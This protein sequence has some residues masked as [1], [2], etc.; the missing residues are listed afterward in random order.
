MEA[1]S[2]VAR[3][4]SILRNLLNNY[5][6]FLEEDTI[7]HEINQYL[8]RLKNTILDFIIKEKGS[9]GIQGDYCQ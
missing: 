4:R 6:L 5:E 2:S 7:I 8:S 3:V 9:R 1:S